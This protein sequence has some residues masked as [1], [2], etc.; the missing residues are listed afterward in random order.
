[1]HPEYGL[2]PCSCNC[3]HDYSEILVYV[4]YMRDCNMGKRVHCDTLARQ[5]ARI[6]MR[7][8]WQAVNASHY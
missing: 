3:D 8:S 1:M 7:R 2:G 6:S 4:A 5:T